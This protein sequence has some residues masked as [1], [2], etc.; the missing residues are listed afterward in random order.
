MEC[1]GQLCILVMSLAT[2]WTCLGTE[3]TVNGQSPEL[4]TRRFSWKNE[5]VEVEHLSGCL[6]GRHPSAPVMG[7]A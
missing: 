3:E 5:D 4:G 6:G 1:D 7:G 2:L